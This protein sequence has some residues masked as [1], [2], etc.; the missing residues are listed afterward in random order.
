VSPCK[1]QQSEEDFHKCTGQGPR[2]PAFSGVQMFWSNLLPPSSRYLKVVFLCRAPCTETKQIV[3]STNDKAPFPDEWI[4][5]PT[6]LL[7][8]SIFFWDMTLCSALSCTRRFGGT[9]RLHLQGRRI[10]QQLNALHDVISQKKILCS[11]ETSGAT[12]CTTRRHT[13][14]EDTLQN[15]RCENLKSYTDLLISY[16][17]FILL[18]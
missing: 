11:T 9:Y 15:H 3:P 7:M 5:S 4:S 10:V 18:L 16:S 12:Q 14:E 17:Y 2:L 8:K 6:D 1:Q 13:P